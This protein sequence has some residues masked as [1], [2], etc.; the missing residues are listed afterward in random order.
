MASA[1]LVTGSTAQ[2]HAAERQRMVEEIDAMLASGGG[3]RGVA[4]LTP[5]V[6]AA[7][8]EVPRHEFVPPEYRSAAYSNSP[9][10]IG[11]GQ[12]ISQPLI[13]GLMTELLQLAKTDKVLEVGT[14]SGYQTAILSV[15]AGEVYTIEI[16][17]ELG[18]MARANLER[19][20]YR[21]VSTKI[22]DGYQGWAE[23]APFNA[24]IVTAAPDHVPLP[25]IAQLR[26]DGRMVIPL[27][28]FYQELTLLAK[29]ADG[30]TTTTIIAPVRFVP[31]IRE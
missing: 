10:P 27:G 13:V 31:L 20:G 29:H 8:T 14:G 15:L 12:T 2:Q 19:L 25:L 26:S 4:R 9:L 23:H 28:G 5:R 30:T 21:N 11:H 22:G 7:M 3:T 16:V 18:K 6:R 1:V 17:P 24:I